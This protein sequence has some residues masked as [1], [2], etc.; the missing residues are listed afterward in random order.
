[1]DLISDLETDLAFAFLVEQ[2]FVQKLD[3][4]E[5]IELIVRVKTALE[6]VA[7]AGNTRFPAT[8]IAKTGSQ[9]S[10]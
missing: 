2:K 10:H 4:R 3:N 1:M 9:F 5:V 8:P 6:T 7:T